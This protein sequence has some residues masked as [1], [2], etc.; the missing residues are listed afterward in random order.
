[1]FSKTISYMK[2]IKLMR[3]PLRAFF[4]FLEELNSA[5]KKWT[6]KRSSFSLENQK[7]KNINARYSKPPSIFLL[8]VFK[9]HG[10]EK[11]QFAKDETPPQ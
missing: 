7:T 4:L 1:M 10:E 6:C 5:L 2:Q 11:N 3:Q 9:D 8:F